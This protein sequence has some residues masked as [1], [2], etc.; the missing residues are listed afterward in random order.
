MIYAPSTGSL[1]PMSEFERLVLTGDPYERGKTHGT[2]WG[3]AVAA[4]VK[5]YRRRFENE[6]LDIEAVR[7]RAA[8]YVET[9]DDDHEA[10]AEEIRGIADGSD[11]PLSDVAMLNVRWE[12]LYSALDAGGEDDRTGGSRSADGCTSFGVLPSTTVG[13]KPYLGQNWD[14]LS[15]I[16][17][18]V[19]LVE[20]RPP[21]GTATLAM[22]EAGIVGGKIGVNEHGI[23]LCV[24]G[25]VSAID[26]TDSYGTPY[27]VRFREILDSPRFDRALEAIYT[28]DR[29]CSANVLIGHADGE[30]IDLEA[31]P[32]RV[33]R[34]HP[35]DGVLTHSNHFRTPEIDVPD[36][37][38]GTS[39]FYRAARL[40]R[41]LT[42]GPDQLDPASMQTALR[43][44]FSH[45]AS[46]CNHVD[47]SVPPIEQTQ[48]NASVIIDLDEQR[49][50]ATR[51]P[52]CE[53]EYREYAL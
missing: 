16:E 36:E 41:Q 15:P 44:H 9:I 14:W 34:F 43:D 4:N 23:G 28:G 10:Y 12:I 38:T 8:N 46:I 18:T 17:D 53:G 47:A 19:F 22:T 11:V 20:R 35:R 51:G 27:H 1:E 3:R 24:N 2:E 21:T 52:P 37:P 42:A 32:D 29:A 26:R 5:T 6:G 48:T 7:E 25:L 45:P 49:L 13:G 50:L 33:G 39:T 40:R 30:V 31:A